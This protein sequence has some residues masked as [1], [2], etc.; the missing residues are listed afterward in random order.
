M[1]VY[2]AHQ[3]DLLPYSGFWHKMDKADLFDVKIWDQYNRKGYQRRVT[4]RGFWVT[5]PLVKGSDVV[6][7]ATRQLAPGATGHLADEIVKRY[8]SNGPR[9]PYWDKYGPMICDEIVS[10]RTDLLWELNFRLILLVRDILGIQTPLTFSRPARSD[11]RGPAGIV[12]VMQ[13]FPGPLEYLSGTGAR[14]YMGDCHDFTEAGIPVIWSRH[15]ATTGD[16]ILSVLFD[17]E[18]PM[19]VVR[20]EHEPGHDE[21]GPSSTSTTTESITNEEQ[22]QP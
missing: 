6:P 2:A 8:T 4:M 21:P 10:I 9:P 13:A 16:S 12:S 17:H 19:G 7:I 14:A 1:T 20:A 18:D 11:L 5:L 3:P 15:R 22:V